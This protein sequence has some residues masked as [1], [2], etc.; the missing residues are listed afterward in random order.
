MEALSAE[1]YKQVVPTLYEIALK[2]RYLRDNESKEILDILIN[3]RVYEF[4]YIYG[5][6]EGFGFT[7]G[8]MFGRNNN[9]FESYYQQKYGNAK[10]H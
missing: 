7:L 8:T 4:G 6:F 2:T 3:G 10:I 9:N 5:G 1:S